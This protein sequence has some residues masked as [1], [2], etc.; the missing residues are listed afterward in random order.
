MHSLSVCSSI[1]TIASN[2]NFVK[3]YEDLF[4]SLSLKMQPS[5]FT[6]IFFVTIVVS[7]PANENIANLVKSISQ[8]EEFILKLV[9]DCPHTE[10]QYN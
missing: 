7:G 4:F 9:N 10:K 3:L 2:L 5:V 8:K 6:H 1:C